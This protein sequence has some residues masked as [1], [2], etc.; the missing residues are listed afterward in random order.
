MANEWVRVEDAETGVE[1]WVTEDYLTRWP[2]DYKR[3]GQR[4]VQSPTNPAPVTEQV[5]RDNLYTDQGR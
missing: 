5:G 2:D 3:L 1:R 4:H